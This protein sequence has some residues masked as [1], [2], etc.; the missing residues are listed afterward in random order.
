M[1]V[2]WGI[3]GLGR[4]ARQ[5]AH[6]LQFVEEAHLTAV[7]SR[8]I[9]NAESFAAE[10]GAGRAMGDYRA[11]WDAADVDAV[12]IATP[13]TSHLEQTLA[14]I[15]A[16]KAV[17]CEK[18]LT[19][20][21]ANCLR[22]MAAA[23]ERDGSYVMEGM[24]TYF[25]PAIR[26]ARDWVDEGRIG[27]VR[28]LKADFGYPLPYQPGLRE[29]DAALG[30]GCLLEMGIYPVAMA[31][32]FIG[33][34]PARMDRVL[35]HAPNGVEDDVVAVF[36]YGAAVAA[37]ATSFRVKYQNACYVIGDLGYIAIPDHWRAGECHLHGI[38]EIAESFRDQRR[39]FGFEYEIA[40]V[41]A[42]IEAGRRESGV[43]PLATSLELQRHI[44]S[45]RSAG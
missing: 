23:G 28:H 29:Y 16:G 13:H 25:L 20:S 17:L 37:L 22:I 43:V 32:L 39:G 30:G 3:I 1:T 14:G 41:T 33:G 15:A 42:D 8:S 27:Q 12:Y 11:M 9:A 26:Q 24:W 35:R 5:F 6:D 18:P 40:A 34:S 2:R 45:I 38:D 44:E 21:S 4:I 7:A 31:S 10:F 36:D 19:T